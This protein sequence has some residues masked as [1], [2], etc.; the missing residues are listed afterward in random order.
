MTEVFLGQIMLTGFA[1]A[2]RGFALCNG[3]L[4]PI[5]Q[6]AALFSLLGVQYG[7]DGITTFALP[8]MQ[9]RTPVGAGASVDGGWN[10]AAYPQGLSAGVES[11]TL[12]SS[13]VPTHTA[14]VYGTS[15]TGAVRNPT[16]SLYGN[17]ASALFGPDNGTLV[18]LLG[19]GTGGGN[20]A[21][22]NIQPYTVVNFIIAVQGIFP[23]RD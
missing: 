20:Q 22:P 12:V 15:A 8:N 1:F 10:P 9:S 23:S 21:H 11:V 16:N 18:P 13:N 14:T 19:V 4:L 2:P 7:G 3:Q 5:N 17:D 6:N